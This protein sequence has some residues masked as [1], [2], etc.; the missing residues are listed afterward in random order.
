MNSS[1]TES[2]AAYYSCDDEF[3][4][5][6][7]YFVNEKD[8]EFF[9]SSTTL[10]PAL[11]TDVLVHEDQY[12][13]CPLF[14]EAFP[15]V[16]SNKNLAATAQSEGVFPGSFSLLSLPNLDRTQK[17][18]DATLERIKSLPTLDIFK[19]DREEPIGDSLLSVLQINEYCLSENKCSDNVQVELTTLCRVDSAKDDFDADN[20]EAGNDSMCLHVSEY[21]L[22]HHHKSLRKIPDKLQ[23]LFSADSFTEDNKE[24]EIK[25]IKQRSASEEKL[26]SCDNHTSS[27]SVASSSAAVNNCDLPSHP[28][29]IQSNLVGAEQR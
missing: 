4:I 6:S 9:D 14:Q 1:D 20:T 13:D 27:S 15:L 26:A 25:N 12:D 10:S 16:L 3:D 22:K 21:S 2:E 24:N 18:F 28:N 11:K 7:S 29:S 8:D 19:I 5:D 17:E 23:T